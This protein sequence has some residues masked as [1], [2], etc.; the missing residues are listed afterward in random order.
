MK[1]QPNWRPS[2]AIAKCLGVPHQ[3]LLLTQRKEDTT[4][5]VWVTT[6]VLVFCATSLAELHEQWFELSRL[7]TAWL[8]EQPHFLENRIELVQSAGTLLGV[9]DVEELLVE[10]FPEPKD[11]E[12]AALEKALGDDWKICYLEEPPYT[13]YFWNEK[14]NHSTWRNPVERARQ[15]KER[16][17]KKM[18]REAL[19]ARALPMRLR[20]NRDAAPPDR[21]RR[22]CDD[23]LK[24]RRATI[25]EASV[26]CLACD[27][28]YYCDDC[29]DRAHMDRQRVVHIE[30]SF[31]FV[32][33][34]GIHGF[35]RPPLPSKR[36]LGPPSH[37]TEA[38]A[39]STA[40]T[41]AATVSPTIS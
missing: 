17:E 29:C 40:T 25:N 14:T 9:R 12:T 10:M 23:C 5:S 16:I 35:P 2:Q 39:E 41:T 1:S 26:L 24:Q 3:R 20:I 6:L 22:A 31:R 33:C 30:T 4:N 7:A 8:Y 18:R 32:D 34:C 27:S 37:A 28:T 38:A 15:E 19:L 21:P 36:V 11:P 13:M